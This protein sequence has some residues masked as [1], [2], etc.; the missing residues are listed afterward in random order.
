MLVVINTRHPINHQIFFIL[1]GLRY[2][3]MATWTTINQK[4]LLT[5]PRTY[6]ILTLYLPYT[7]PVLSVYRMYELTYL[8]QQNHK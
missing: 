5:L 1:N 8:H 3:S 4:L 7:Y 6:P 2:L